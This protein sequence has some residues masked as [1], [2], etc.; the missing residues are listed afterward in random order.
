MSMRRL[1]AILA[2]GILASCGTPPAGSPLDARLLEIAGEYLK[3]GRVDDL[4]RWAPTL[5]ALHPSRARFSES[6]DDAT[7]GRK[8]YYLFARDRDAYVNGIKNP[9]PEGQVIVKEAW[10][11]VPV[12]GF[13]IPEQARNDEGGRY[14]PDAKLD[15]RTYTTGAKSGLFIMLKRGG[16]W[17]Y[18]TVT[19][20]G[21]R[22][23]QS[24][25]VTSCIGCHRD[26][27]PDSLFGLPGRTQDR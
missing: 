9:Q 23:L 2:A 20:E 17:T 18:A 1:A 3:Y 24:G 26:A 15:E 7:H 19:P 4:N 16:G 11:P 12:E 14:V 13:E 8:I 25:Q 21:D 5:C 10:N 27:K 6:G 22:V